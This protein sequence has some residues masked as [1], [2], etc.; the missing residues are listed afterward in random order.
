MIKRYIPEIKKRNHFN[1]KA[2]ST[3]LTIV[4]I[5]SLL[6]SKR[7]AVIDFLLP[8]DRQ[9]TRSAITNMVSRIKSGEPLSA[10]VEAFC[11]EIVRGANIPQ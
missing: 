5:L 8:G 1:I 4:T 7:D 2:L 9:I 3:L 11:L 6:I 10:S